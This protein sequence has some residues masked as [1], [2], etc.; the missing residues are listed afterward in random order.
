MRFVVNFHGYINGKERVCSINTDLW[1]SS[2]GNLKPNL[3]GKTV[4][5]Q[6]HRFCRSVPVTL[7]SR[8]AQICTQ[9]CYAVS[10]VMHHSVHEPI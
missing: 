6:V 7:D 3:S 1:S 2:P 5:V 9:R 4:N 8:T 10:R